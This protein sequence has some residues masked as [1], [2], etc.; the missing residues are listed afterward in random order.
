MT[1]ELYQN[2]IVVADRAKVIDD[3]IASPILNK[4]FS[5]LAPAHIITAEFDLSRD[6]SERYGEMLAAAGVPVTTK[7][8][9]GVPHAFAHYNVSL[10]FLVKAR[11]TFRF[12]VFSPVSL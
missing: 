10:I 11:V 8:Y 6:E 2:R 12:F 9:P 5:G 7:R 3:P 1:D 4:S